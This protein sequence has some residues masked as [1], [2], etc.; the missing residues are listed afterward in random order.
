MDLGIV[1]LP[2]CGKTTVFNALTHGHA[3]AGGHRA[4]VETHIGVVKV[5]DERL[6]KLAAQFQSKKVTPAELRYLDLP[7]MGA[8]FGRGGPSSQVL[9]ALSASDGL[10]HVVRTFQREDVPHP[11]GSIDPHRDIAAMDVELVLADL[12]IVEKRLERLAPVVRAAKPGEREAGEREMELLRRV[13]AS[14][15]GETPLRAQSLTAEEERALRDYALLTLK[16]ILLVVNVG[17]EDVSRVA[18]IESE[19]AARYAAAGT[20]V[21]ALCGQLEMELAQLS[22]EEAWEFRQELGLTDSGVQ[23]VIQK[24]LDLMGLIT[25]Y[26][27]VGDE[28][29]A[30]TVPRATPAQQAAGKIHSDMEKGFIRAEAIGCQEILVCGSLT[31]ARKRGILRTEGKGYVVQDG[32]VLH[33]LFCV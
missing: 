15:E 21:V 9:S 7:A 8:T 25:F 27:V 2:L 12:A 23:R 17:E 28:C 13:K 18:D 20:P 19:F 5:P 24:T 4:G 29:R 6:N 22:E 3:E 10:L 31:E 16:P 11:Q 33:I 1:G 14:L 26:T 32:D 30:W